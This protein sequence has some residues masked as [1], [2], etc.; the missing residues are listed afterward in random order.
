MKKSVA[1]SLQIKLLLKKHMENLEAN[2]TQDK[3]KI[4]LTK[5]N[6]KELNDT[7]TCELR[8]FYW[9]AFYGL[10]RFVR[11]MLYVKRWSPFMKSFKS[12]SLLSGAIIGK[13][14]EIASIILDEIEYGYKIPRQM[15]NKRP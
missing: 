15:L 12:R 9:A 7:E 8:V 14:T 13:Q 2:E 10:K 11:L 6:K 4:Y 1:L 5:V 3:F